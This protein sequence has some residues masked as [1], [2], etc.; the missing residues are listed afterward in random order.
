MTLHWHAFAYTGRGIKSDAE[1]RNGSAPANFPPL[2]VK[3]WLTRRNKEGRIPHERVFDETQI[4]DAAIWLEA[5]LTRYPPLDVVSFP[6]PDRIGYARERLRQR[7][8]RDIV[9]G[10]WSRGERYVS[11][12]LVLCTGEGTP[13]R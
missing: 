8:N 10:Y 11:R 5:E 4:E 3:D 7:V 1:I 6:I 9:W 12:A 13:C 2:V